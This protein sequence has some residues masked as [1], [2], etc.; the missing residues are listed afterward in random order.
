MILEANLGIPLLFF[1]KITHINALEG[2][3]AETLVEEFGELPGVFLLLIGRVLEVGRETEE[4]LITPGEESSLKYDNRT[5]LVGCLYVRM[6]PLPS[7]R[8]ID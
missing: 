7:P 8:M 3:S 2:H 6:R 1:K 4:S 5:S